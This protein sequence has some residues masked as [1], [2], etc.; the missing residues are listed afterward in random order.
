V[1]ALPVFA[2]VGA[3][4]P[5]AVC[6]WGLCRCCPDVGRCLSGVY[7]HHHMFFSL[8]YMYLDGPLQRNAALDAE[9]VQHVDHLIQGGGGVIR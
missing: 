1:T 8:L 3:A 7:V 4:V 6:R 2:V 9:P 5:A